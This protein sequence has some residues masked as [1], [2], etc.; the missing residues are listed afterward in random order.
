MSLPG[1]ADRSPLWIADGARYGRVEARL[2]AGGGLEIRRHEMGGGE[3]D[4][5]GEDDHEATLQ[6]AP[7]DVAALALALLTERY[8]GRADA[9]EALAEL[10]EAHGVAARHSVWT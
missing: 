6:I 8:A 4:V 9:L 2:T 1:H 10:C 3:R 7:G 5:W